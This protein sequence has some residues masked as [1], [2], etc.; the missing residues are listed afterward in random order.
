MKKLANKKK[1]LV[2]KAETYLLI[3]NI[4][5]G[6]TFIASKI[7]LFAFNSFVILFF[8]NI[9]CIILFYFLYRK[10]IFKAKLKHVA[11]GI[12]IGL[13]VFLGFFFQTEGMLYT[14]VARSAFLTESLIV[15]TP[16]IQF[17]WLRKKIKTIETISIVVVVVGLYLLC[18]PNFKSNEQIINYG[19]FL[20]I[21]GAFAFSF[22]IVSLEHFRRTPVGI[23][24]FYQN[25]VGVL[26]N[27]FIL[28]VISDYKA[29]FISKNYN[30][31]IIFS[32]FYLSFV[33][34][35]LTSF[36]QVTYQPLTTPAR[37]GIIYAAEPI[38]ASLF[39]YLFLKEKMDGL[40]IFGAVITMFGILLLPLTYAKNFSFKSKVKKKP[41]SKKK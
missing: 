39:A 1:V 38:I 21:L 8:R 24:L 34:S 20:T 41:K 35:G 11:N 12:I 2:Y 14:S 31:Y 13:L 15:F 16:I 23:I 22:Y 37:A 6:G 33:G 32:L 28:F 7:A 30:S 19:D 9:T 4:F 18:N 17:F 10:L 25:V 29:I 40:E 27:I 3:T 26:I 5:W 36:L